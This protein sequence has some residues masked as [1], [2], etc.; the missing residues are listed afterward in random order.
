VSNIAQTPHSQRAL[1][2]RR[3]L[4]QMRR[5]D[6]SANDAS[7]RH[8]PYI[9]VWRKE[10]IIKLTRAMTRQLLRGV[11][12]RARL[13]RPSQ[14]KTARKVSK[15]GHFRAEGRL[16]HAACDAHVEQE[17][18]DINAYIKGRLISIELSNNLAKRKQYSPR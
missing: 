18:G 8:A 3:R 13:P 7:R 17:R 11:V 10:R 9:C 4:L 2:C 5:T 6:I 12:T 1:G 15:K 16:T 14:T